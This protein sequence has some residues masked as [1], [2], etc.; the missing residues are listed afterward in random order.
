MCSM[1][2]AA[3]AMGR[4]CSLRSHDRWSASSIPEPT[5]RGA[6]GNFPRPNLQFL[7]GDARA[8]PLADA[9]VDCVVSFETIEHFDRQDDFLREVRRVLRPDGSFIVS[10]PDRDVYSPAGSPANPFHVHELSR[11]E[12]ASLLQRHLSPC[13]VDAATRADRLGA[14]RRQ[15]D[16]RAAA[17]VRPAR[18]HAFRGL[19]RSAARALSA[20][21]GIG[22]RTAAIAAQPLYRSQRSRY[23]DVPAIGDRRS[24]A[25]GA[26]DLARHKRPQAAQP[27]TAMHINRRASGGTGEATSGTGNGTRR[28]GNGRAEQARQLVERTTQRAEQAEHAR[29][30]CEERGEA[31]QRRHDL[32]AGSLRTFLRGYLPRLV[33][34]CSVSGRS[35]GRSVPKSRIFMGAGSHRCARFVPP[36][37]PRVS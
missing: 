8:L 36:F 10:T 5:V 26:A 16:R 31:V 28:T 21:G 24:I 3:K 15:S 23:R 19:R 37:C 9:C 4:R 25:T 35:V 11:S 1:W 18:R 29:V 33:A 34:T 27:P 22:S 20:R 6:A 30:E 13:A 7:Q 14:A 2:R 32:L 17:G 12:F